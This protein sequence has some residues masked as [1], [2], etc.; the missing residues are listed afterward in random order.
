MDEDFKEVQEK[1][2]GLD[3][4]SLIEG[5]LIAAREAQTMLAPSTAEFIDEIDL[6]PENRNTSKSKKNTDETKQK[7]E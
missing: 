2:Q 4:E 3:V 5:P 7:T 6:A 1:F